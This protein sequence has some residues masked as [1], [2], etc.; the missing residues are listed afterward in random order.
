MQRRGAV[1]RN[2]CAAASNFVQKTQ[3]ELLQEARKLRATALVIMSTRLLQ[4]PLPPLTD[5]SKKHA[6]RAQLIGKQ[7]V[8]ENVPRTRAL[9]TCD[10]LTLTARGPPP[11]QQRAEQRAGGELCSSPSSLSQPFCDQSLWRGS[12]SFTRMKISCP[13][14]SRCSNSID[15]S[16]ISPSVAVRRTCSPMPGPSARAL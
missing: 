8:C 13:L 10:W 11:P 12:P 9:A 15:H 6:H 16:W 7:V 4:A 1:A 2:K 3:K 5:L 14:S